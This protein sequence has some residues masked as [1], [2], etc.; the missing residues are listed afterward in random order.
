MGSFLRQVLQP[1]DRPYFGA[2][3]LYVPREQYDH[4]FQP[5][6]PRF[7]ALLLTRPVPDPAYTTVAPPAP[8]PTY[9][10]RGPRDFLNPNPP[11]I[12]Y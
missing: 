6:F 3:P 4:N 12:G 10:T 11:N 5:Y 8:M 7:R 1:V 9:T 2:Q